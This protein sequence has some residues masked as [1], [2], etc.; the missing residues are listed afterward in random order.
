MKNSS[1]KRLEARGIVAPRS[2]QNRAAPTPGAQAH[3]DRKN[4]PRAQIKAR[5]RRELRHEITARH[6]AGR[7]RLWF[8]FFALALFFFASQARA[9]TVK[10]G[11]LM[12]NTRY[13]TPFTI[14][15]GD[16]KGPV[17]AV[18]GGVHGDEKAGYL[19]ARELKKWK[20]ERG[21]LVLV[22]DAHI[23][24]IRRNVRAY[25][26]NMNALFPGKKDGDAMEQLAFQIWDLLKTNKPDLLLTLHESRGFYADDPKRY[27]QTFTF[28]FPELR[29][30]FA[31]VAAHLNEQI[32]TPKHR[33]LIKVEAFKTCP[34]YC[35]FKYLGVPATSIETARTLPLEVRLKYQILALRAF[36][37]DAG[38]G[39]QPSP[40]G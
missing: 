24:A 38:L 28:D 31:G 12:K 4:P 23:E 15:T 35:A 22:P 39:Y 29:A 13:Q 21:T 16:E 7:D 20:I 1:K 2:A 26:R 19:A 37:D 11:F 27:G 40:V 9:E 30:H 8:A 5:T 3:I 36:F 14:K 6:T 10:T 18:I 34:T 17:I 32:T 33:F 25:P